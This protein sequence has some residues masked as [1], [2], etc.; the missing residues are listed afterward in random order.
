MIE[1]HRPP[2]SPAA[3]EIASALQ[4]MVVAFRVVE[5]DALEGPLIRDG[6]HVHGSPEAVSSYLEQLRRD[7]TA[8]NAFQSDSCY[9]GDDG[10]VC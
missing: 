9:I 2:D 5:D 10:R 1:L 3:D 7:V 6:E 8:W 4:N